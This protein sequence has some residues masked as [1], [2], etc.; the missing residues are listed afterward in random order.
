MGMKRTMERMGQ[1]LRLIKTGGMIP[2]ASACMRSQ[3]L[4]FWG[5]S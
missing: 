3:K 4:V 1:G 5:Y 2:V